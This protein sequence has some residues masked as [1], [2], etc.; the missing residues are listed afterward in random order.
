MRSKAIA[1]RQ[2]NLSPGAG[3]SPP[4]SVKC[5][6]IGAGWWG[7]TA[8]IP[9]LQSHP[10]AEL[11]AVHSK[12]PQKARQIAA[13]FKTPHGF[14][15]VDELLS[16]DGLDAV[17]ISSTPN[18]H[19][20]QARAALKKG[21][22]V[23][24]EKPMTIAPA[25]SEEL[26]AIANE[27]GCHFLISC[28]WHY[29][30]HAREARRI[31]QSGM[32]G[33]IKMISVLMTNFNIG[34]YRGLP[35][36]QIFGKNS[37]LQNSARPYCTPE[38]DS[39]CDPEVAGGG[40]I[41]SQI[42]HA[43]AHIGFITGSDPANV[44]AQFDKADTRVDVYNTINVTLEDGTLVSMASTGATPDTQRNYEVRIYGTEGL[45]LMELWKGK[46]ECH[47]FDGRVT[48]YPDLGEAEIYP[49]FAPAQNLV[50][51]ILGREE[52]GSPAELG[53]YAM[54]VIGAAC[55]SARTNAR[56][57]VT[58]GHLPTT[59]QTNRYE[60]ETRLR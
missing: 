39:Y 43:A 27:E 6:V 5:A 49:M 45:L 35:W 25:E 16:L 10:A 52:N 56:V 34:L 53:L 54:K 19:Y 31:V 60:T 21:L 59:K 58:N 20:L 23:L 41:Y 14:S 7:T 47:Y 8:H 18:V 30:A 57:V 28:P 15:D 12:D 44:F 26:I 11:V 38:P 51:V 9:A 17:I 37:T 24:I 40:Q 50:D 42:P 13:D 46:M 1:V 36:E 32:L 33:R 48:H 3:A 4:K 55:E 29:T 22:H 2:F